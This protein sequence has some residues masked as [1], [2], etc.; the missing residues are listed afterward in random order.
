[1]TPNT[2]TR[3]FQPIPW[4]KDFKGKIV[5]YILSWE[6]R[7][8]VGSTTDIRSRLANWKSFFRKEDIEDVFCRIYEEVEEQDRF[9]RE[10]LAILKFRTVFPRGHNRT[11]SGSSAGK[12]ESLRQELRVSLNLFWSSISCEPVREKISK[13][14]KTYFEDNSHRENL[15]VKRKEYLGTEEGMAQN[16]KNNETLREF[17]LS[18]ASKEAKK[19]VLEYNSSTER[20]EKLSKKLKEFYSDPEKMAVRRELGRQAGKSEGN[21]KAASSR[22]NSIWSDPIKAAAMR[23]RM[24][25]ARARKAAREKENALRISD[26]REQ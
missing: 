17:W 12:C 5:V 11:S 23:E 18:D 25:G 4:I 10:E 3:L 13:S 9:R 6:G 24:K 16:K 7:M 1:M 19:K 20:R 26:T 14:K 21:R 15:S 8:Y 22:M 2:F